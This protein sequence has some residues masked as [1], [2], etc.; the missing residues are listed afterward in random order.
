MA[1]VTGPGA[2]R[3]VESLA[4]RLLDEHLQRIDRQCRALS[5]QRDALLGDA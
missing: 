2:A 1:E 5:D 3:E 4:L